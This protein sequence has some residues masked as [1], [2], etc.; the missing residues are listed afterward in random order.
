MSELQSASPQRTIHHDFQIHQA[1]FCDSAR[2]AQMFSNLLA[3][4]LKHGDPASP[5][6]V[7]AQNSESD[8]ELSVTNLGATIE[9]QVME[10]LFEPFVRGSAKP[11]QEGLGLGLYI[12]T[13]IAR[14]HEGTLEV[15]SVEGR[16]C[17][18]FRMSVSPLS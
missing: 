14:A 5:I 7:A 13:E 9:P 11:G 3:N 15:T 1:V 17:F 4:A 12:A 18:T 16:T 6:W 8:F 2:L 10:Q